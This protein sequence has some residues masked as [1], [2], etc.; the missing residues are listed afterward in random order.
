MIDAMSLGYVIPLSG[1]LTVRS[2]HDC[3]TIEVTSS[4]QM[5]VCEFHDI[6]QLGE[7]SAPGFPAPPLKFVNPWIVKTAPGW[8]TLFIAP[9]NNFESHFTCLSGLVDTDT[10]PKEVN[11]PAIWHTPNADVLLL[12]GTPL[13]IA[14]PIKRDAVPSK[15]N[16]RNMKE[17]EHHLINIISKMQN[18]RRSVYTK[19]LRVPRK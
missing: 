19:E 10:Y 13:V 5:N 8:S 16:I 2:N 1:D 11:F 3:S 14:I 6:R 7:K 15:P 4:P 12:A 18:T 9:I 17:D